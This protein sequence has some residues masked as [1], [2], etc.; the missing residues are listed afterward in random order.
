MTQ[1]IRKNILVIS[2]PEVA[3]CRDLVLINSRTITHLDSQER[4]NGKNLAWQKAIDVRHFLKKYA[5]DL[6]LHPKGPHFADFC[7]R[8]LVYYQENEDGFY[9]SKADIFEVEVAFNVCRTDEGELASSEFVY[10]TREDPEFC[11]TFSSLE[12]AITWLERHTIA[13]EPDDGLIG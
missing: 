7:F 5:F 12:K 13:D 8:V 2:G 10:V 9:F 1:R 4:L 6:V 3:S 11:K